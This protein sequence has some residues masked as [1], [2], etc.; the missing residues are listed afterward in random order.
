MARCGTAILQALMLL[1]APTASIAGQ[2]RP[3][4]GY[5][6]RDD[7]RPYEPQG[8]K[9]YR[10]A[11]DPRR[12]TATETVDRDVSTLPAPPPAWQVR[13]VSPD[14]QSIAATSYVVKPGDT[15]R[16]IAERT[17]A[18]SEVIARANRLP[19]PFFVHAGQR[20]D[21]PGGRY[22]RVRV[23]QTGIAIARAY[24]MD[25]SR[26]VA[27][28]DLPAPYTLRVGMRV[29][30]PGAA[31]SSTAAERAA[32]FQLDIDDIVTGAEPAL[33]ANVRPAKPAASPRRVLSSTAAIAQPKRLT[34]GF[35]WPVHGRILADFGT[36]AAGKTLN[37]VKI[38]A[39]RGTPIRAAADGVVAY[40][41]SGIP[42]LGGV[43]ILKHGDDWTTVYGH[44][45]QL[46]VQRG[47]SVKRG[48]TVALSGA[49]GS[50]ERPEV[51]FE[52]RKGRIPVDPQQ[53]LPGI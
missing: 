14:A 49:S 30:I 42:T 41:G 25:W 38:A 40:A 2:D 8:G 44:A 45:S 19:P 53:Q 20:L 35:A 11:L 24:G 10:A 47:Q 9:P 48:Q 52:M 34:S 32:A 18:G 37:G 31:G 26:I 12:T 6:P 29:L 22:H 43:V 13:P 39:A 4:R 16:T 28:N 33:A 3:Q 50:A 36:A 5:E 51:H 46:L 23:G 7:Q 17:G 15:L 1:A 27:A 21:I